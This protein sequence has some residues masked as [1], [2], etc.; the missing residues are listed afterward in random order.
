MSVNF[1]RKTRYWFGRY[2]LQE[3]NVSQAVAVPNFVFSCLKH[4]HVFKSRFLLVAGDYLHTFLR[5]SW[6]F[7]H[8]EEVTSIQN[9]EAIKTSPRSS[10]R[11]LITHSSEGI[12][13]FQ[14]RHSPTLEAGIGHFGLSPGR[15]HLGILG[16]HEM[17][18]TFAF[19]QW[20][21]CLNL[22]TGVN[23]TGR[24]ESRGKNRNVTK[25]GF[26]CGYCWGIKENQS[27]N[28]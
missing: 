27:H 15:K 16:N 6:H 23:P 19:A 14:V 9:K 22:G 7:K 13:F 11:L 4:W 12:G 21:D 18:A 3:M 28:A 2:F 1:Q 10:R 17:C 24:A 25:G 5:F 26:K 8:L 20:G